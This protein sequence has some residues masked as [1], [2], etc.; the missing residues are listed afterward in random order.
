LRFASPSPKL[1]GERKGSIDLT[2]YSRQRDKL[3]EELTLAKIEHHTEAV[4]ELD[5]QGILAFAER[6]LPRA[7]D[8]WAQASLDY[9]QR[10]QQLFFLEGIAFDE[11]RFNRTAAMARGWKERLRLQASA[12]R[13][14]PKAT[15]SAK[16]DSG[17]PPRNRTE[18]PQIK[19]LLLCQLS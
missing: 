15:A 3:R 5:V 2:S 13:Q 4:D 8:L 12:G 17:E 6:I 14:S 1:T 7:S 10:L 16:L 19:S 9:R 18:N 11:N